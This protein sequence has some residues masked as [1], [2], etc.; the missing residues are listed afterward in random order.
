M[1]EK[2]DIKVQGEVKIYKQSRMSPVWKKVFEDHNLVV[3]HA[4]WLI[5]KLMAGGGSDFA[6]NKMVFTVANSS[7]VISGNSSTVVSP[8]TLMP[9]ISD[10]ADFASADILTGIAPE[11]NAKGEYIKILRFITDT[12]WQSGES[13]AKDEYVLYNNAIYKCNNNSGCTGVTMTI[14]ENNWVIQAETER[15]ITSEINYIDDKIQI[16]YAKVFD[17]NDVELSESKNYNVIGLASN[18]L[19]N[20]FSVKCLGS[21]S[22]NKTSTTRFKIEWTITFNKIEEVTCLETDKYCNED[23]DCCSGDCSD[24]TNKCV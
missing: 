24:V 22:I 12:E 7:C 10:S 8:S 16:K 23:T 1:N 4:N 20:L 17:W 14:D 5:A 2:K 6:I 9:M 18:D 11:T 3:N 15:D 13:Y 21:Q 19:E